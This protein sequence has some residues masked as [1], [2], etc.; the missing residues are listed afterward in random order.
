MSYWLRWLQA[1][2]WMAMHD[3]HFG[4]RCLIFLSSPVLLK[5]DLVYQTA[6][7]WDASWWFYGEFQLRWPR[8]WIRRLEDLPEHPG[9]EVPM[10]YFDEIP[11]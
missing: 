7:H 6:L 1:V 3:P 4:G 10:T 2:C 8:L 9:G 5:I 11:F